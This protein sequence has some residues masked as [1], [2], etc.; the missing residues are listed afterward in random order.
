M[1]KNS[2]KTL[3]TLKIKIFNSNFC[4]PLI[5]LTSSSPKLDVDKYPK[6]VDSV[7]SFSDRARALLKSA[8]SSLEERSK[9]PVAV[10]LELLLLS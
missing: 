2:L 8:S 6:G 10:S 4:L 9:F 5:S 3:L 7:D 1:T